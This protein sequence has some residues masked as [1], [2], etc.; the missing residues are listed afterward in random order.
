MKPISILTTDDKELTGSLIEHPDPFG[1]T[2]I[3]GATGVPYQYYASF[4]KWYANEKN[5]HVLFYEYRDSGNLTKAQ[6]RASKTK[7]ADWGITDQSAALDYAL[8]NFPD[9]PI[10]TIGHSLGGFCLPFHKNAD[11]VVS[12]TTVNSGLAYWPTHPWS[13]TLQVIMFWFVLGPL[14]VKILGYLPG[15][16]LGMKTNLPPN[17]Y[18]QWRKWCTNPDLHE[19][20]WGKE[21]PQPDL[22]RFKGKL[23]I[24]GTK[25]DKTIPPARVFILDR[26]FPAAE[27]DKRLIE[28]AKLGLKSVGHIAIF[29]KHN[30]A[31]WPEIIR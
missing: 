21:L 26:F 15:I 30:A 23:I 31:A 4:A 5:H 19:V 9:L 7:M 14:A 20:E 13:F 1:V 29:S 22:Q 17:V 8:E 3:H 12:H 25:D 2:I 11:K 16:L 27:V 10:H 18:W 24:I 28:P 6:I